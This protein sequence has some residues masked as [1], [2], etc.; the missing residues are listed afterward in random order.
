MANRAKAPD[1]VVA[2]WTTM[3]TEATEDEKRTRR[4]FDEATAVLRTM[5]RDAF[6]AG[7][8]ADEIRSVTGRTV[9]RLYQ[10]KRGSR[11]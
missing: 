5:I 2:Y 7:L 8:V 9:N 4:A 11:T 3:L 10:I 6:D 1:D